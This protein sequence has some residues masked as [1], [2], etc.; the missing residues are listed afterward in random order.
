MTKGLNTL[1]DLKNLGQNSPIQNLF[2]TKDTL[3]A[4]LLFE[5]L[6]D[7]FHCLFLEGSELLPYDFFSSSPVIRAS[8]LN[9]F[10]ELAKR[11]NINLI[12]SIQTL[13]SPCPDISHVMPINNMKVGDKLNLENLT[14]FL[15]NNGYT[16][17]DFASIPGEYALRGSILDIF[18]TSEKDPIRIEFFGNNIESLRKF[19]PQTQIASEQIQSINHLPSFE[20]PLNEKSVINFKN[21]WRNKLNVFEGDSEIFSKIIRTR[22]AEGV[23]IYLP[24]FYGHKTTLI[25]YIN[26]MK[27]IYIQEGVAEEANNFQELVYERYEEYRY[28]QKRP[29]LSPDDLFI[30]HKD[31]LEYAKDRKAHN[32]KLDESIEIE[33]KEEEI[34]ERNEKS[35][36]SLQNMPTTND[37]VVHLTHGIGIFNGLKHIDTFVGMTDCLEIEYANKSK[38]YVPIEHMNLVSKY[39][40]PKDRPIDALG[41]KRWVARKDKALKQTFDTAAELLQVQAKRSS[42]KGFSYEVPIKEYQ[43]FCSRFPYQETFDQ[44][45][46]IDEVIIDMQKPVPM[47]RLVC[48]EVGFGKTEV[49]MRAAFIAAFNEKQTCILVPTTLLASQHFSSFIDRFE[50][51]GVEIGVL[52]RNVKNKEKKELLLKLKEGKIDILI[53]THAVLQNN[54]K[55]DDLGLLVIDEEHRFGVRQ[56]EKIKSLKEEVEIISLSATP[57][58]RSLNFALTAL[59]D[60]SIIA[61]AP[62]N[63]LPVKTFVYSFN[64]NLINEAIQRET[65]RNGQTYYLCNDLKLIEDRKQRLNSRFPDLKIEIVHG[66][67]NT[68]EIEEKM[69]SFHAGEI[70]VLVCSTIIESGIDIPNANTLIVEEADKLGL[71]QLHQLRGRIGRSNKQAYSYFLRSRHIISKKSADKRLEALQETD[72]LSAGF[73]LALKDLEIRGAGEILGSNQSGVFDSIGLDL[74]TRMIKRATDFIKNGDLDFHNLDELPEVNINESCLIPEDYLPDINVRLLM[75]NRIAL[76]SSEEELRKIQVEMINRFGLFPNEIKHFFY[77]AELRL[78]SEENSITKINFN[79]DKIN[80]F[81]KNTD[82]NTS[83]INA[84]DIESKINMTKDVIKVISPNVN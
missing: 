53:G 20:Y 70:D 27:K 83:L 50:S 19:D 65:L 57:I 17:S 3:S 5:E 2:V 68:K 25:D 18:L 80:I 78:L 15:S 36:L 71:A 22:P 63:R 61:T 4:K 59:K 21:N 42:R 75:Y 29:L 74:Y 40:G 13:L 26:K 72:S 84:E 37:L 7:E 43:V 69:I 56:K 60:L 1:T 33:P 34:K 44:K 81:F 64:E 10:S 73:L 23:E 49:I 77:Q 54:I 9:C 30:K 79:K 16:R 11:S 24:L 32:F 31:F 28:D 55:F 76:A 39:F 41:S 47:D 6:K 62:D 58:P 45:K 67:L 14:D 12:V 8:R 52:S 51:T 38:V 48:G 82:L 46:T 35:D 66:Q